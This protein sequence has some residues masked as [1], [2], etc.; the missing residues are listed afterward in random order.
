MYRVLY[1]LSLS[2]DLHANFTRYQR[3]HF[4]RDKLESQTSTREQCKNE[5]IYRL[6]IER[7]RLVYNRSARSA[8]DANQKRRI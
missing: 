4:T 6:D 2:S 1:L 7:V 3:I 8:Y 5:Q